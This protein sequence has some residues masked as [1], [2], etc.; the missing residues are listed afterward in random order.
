MI[1]RRKISLIAVLFFSSIACFAQKKA[2]SRYVYLLIGTYTNE[3]SQGIY[4]YRFD[5]KS[6]QTAFIRSTIDVRNPSYLAISADKKY[7]YAVNED[8]NSTTD[9][10]SA[11][12]FND[13]TGKLT[14]INIRP[15]Y[16]KDPCYVSVDKNNKNLFVA[17]YSSGNIS[18]YPLAANGAI[19]D[20]LQTIQHTGGSVDAERQKTP[21]VHAVVLTPNEKFLIADDLGT[22]KVYKYIYRP[23]NKIPLIPAPNATVSVD[24]GSGPRHIIFSKNGQHAYLAQEISGAVRTFNYQN[25]N[26]VPIQ[27]L[28]MEDASFKGI[29][30]AADIHIAP[31]GR[32]LYTSNRGEANDILVYKINPKNGKLSFVQR[33]S[34]LGNAPRN[35]AIDPTGKF[36]LAA[37]QNTNDIY[38]FVINPT[39]GKLTYTGRKLTLSHPVCLN[40]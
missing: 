24:A 5:T 36:L 40:L 11:F 18:V 19:G 34:S 9:S 38:T 20:T 2:S 31:N 39:N 3:G 17:N 10:V 14:F 33:Q 35:F 13:Y 12:K 23:G 15:A 4:T 6:G 30:G 27:N 7:I 1:F 22:D 21:H 8:H 32:F 37:N 28:M 29:N 25:G 16:G 26:L